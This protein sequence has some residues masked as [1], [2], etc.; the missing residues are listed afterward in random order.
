MAVDVTE[1]GTASMQ[2]LT[3]EEVGLATRNHG[4]YLEAL[5]YDVTPI[6]MHYL[7][8]HYDVPHVA[9][10]EWRLTIDGCVDNPLTLSLEDLRVRPSITQ[11]VTMECAGNGRMGLSPRPLSQPWGVEAV[12]N[13]EWT[14]IS[15]AALLDEAGLDRSARE[16]VFTGLDSGV[17]NGVEQS[18]ARSLA[19]AEAYRD[20]V[21]LAYQL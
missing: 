1:A 5:R 4:F 8:T 11:R 9:E 10:H 19:L 14:G 20:D 17:E 13:G 7:L 16:I 3:P 15:L 6:G 21:A 12:G 2:S 18:Y